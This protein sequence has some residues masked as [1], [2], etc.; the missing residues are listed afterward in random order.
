M[1]SPTNAF[2]PY[3]DGGGLF[4][5]V[6][7]GVALVG[8]TPILVPGQFVPLTSNTTNYVLL[9]L[10]SGIL[11]VNTSGFT[12]GNYPI[13]IVTTLNTGVLSVVDAR[14]DVAA[15]GPGGGGGGGGSATRYYPNEV[16]NSSIQVFHF[17]AQAASNVNFQLFWSGLYQNEIT[18]YTISLGGGQTTVTMV[19]TP[20]TGDALVAY[21]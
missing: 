7:S 13:A 8:S 6:T 12:S 18:D 1:I 15:A 4:L 2:S 14:P 9:N 3:I 5:G 20:Q 19:L 16:P 21:F 11:Q 17:P 10:T